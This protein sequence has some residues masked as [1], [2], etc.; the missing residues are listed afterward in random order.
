MSC[1]S[2][3]QL[4]DTNTLISQISFASQIFE[5]RE[6]QNKYCH[7]KTEWKSWMNE[8]VFGSARTEAVLGLDRSLQS[9]RRNFI[10]IQSE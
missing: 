6:P 2:Y 1:K 10:N 8:P 7:F 5:G 4:R 9:N 3:V